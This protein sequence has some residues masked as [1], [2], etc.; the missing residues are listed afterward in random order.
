MPGARSSFLFLVVRNDFPGFL[1]CQAVVNGSQSAIQDSP[2]DRSRTI[3]LG[4][5]A[6]L[7]LFPRDPTV[8]GANTG[9]EG[10]LNATE[11]VDVWS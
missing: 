4:G 6:F 1:H 11:P 5:V 8:W 3:G 2:G 10:I 7:R 9:N